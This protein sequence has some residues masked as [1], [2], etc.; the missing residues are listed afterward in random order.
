MTAL[1]E[2]LSRYLPEEEAK[3]TAQAAF[4]GLPVVIDGAQGPTGKSTL[5]AELLKYGLGAFEKYELDH[6]P[7]VGM[8][9]DKNKVNHN[10]AYV[11]IVLN[12]L[13]DSP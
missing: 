8:L 5:C 12:K 11:M 1:Q 9:I 2:T 10:G 4:N 3:A 7:A 6:D 13:I